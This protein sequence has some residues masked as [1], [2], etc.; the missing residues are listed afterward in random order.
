MIKRYLQFIK[1][2]KS[3][4]IKSIW[5][6]WTL[7]NEKV[8]ELFLDLT[9]SGFYISDIENGVLEADSVDNLD[10][11]AKI[12]CGM[13]YTPCQCI[14]IKN[15]RGNVNND[16]LTD[17]LLT[18]IEYIKEIGY[19]VDVRDDNGILDIDTIVVGNDI[20]INGD[21]ELEGPLQII[22][23]EEVGAVNT[24]F[25]LERGSPRIVKFTESEVM[26]YYS[27]EA[28]EIIDG[29]PYI[30]IS[31]EDLANKI[32]S[33]KDYYRDRLINGIDYDHY[34]NSDFGPDK[35][36]LFQYYLD[37]ENEVDIV[38][39]LIDE[40][41]GFDSV[42]EEYNIDVET[43][44]ELIAF[45]LKERYYKTIV[46]MCN[47]S[48][49]DMIRDVESN[50]S[51]LYLGAIHSAHEKELEYAFD[52]IVSDNFKYIKDNN[53]KGVFY[54]IKFNMEWLEEDYFDYDFLSSYPLKDIFD[55]YISREYWEN[56]MSPNFSDY[57]D[58]DNK[59]FNADVK[60]TLKW[61]QKKDTE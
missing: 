24:L 25:G 2:Q 38:K 22:V 35:Q 28:D 30:Y 8:A 14:S 55:E 46:D 59:E 48:D 47:N 17:S 56:S 16:D 40:N 9:D 58:V 42:K 21:L 4:E 61:Y 51:D 41:G 57:A 39:I 36:S 52:K 18:A 1:E 27:W 15:P 19:K 3:S 7:T 50:Y 29:K 11:E 45:L 23:C 34:E 31:Q 33:S 60:H 44:E 13:E 54:K 26:E 37:K 43:E 10:M 6:Y 12:L 5:D 53:D 20:T 32:L 49:S